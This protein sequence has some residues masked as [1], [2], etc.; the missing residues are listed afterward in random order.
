[1]LLS[2]IGRFSNYTLNFEHVPIL[3]FGSNSM[4]QS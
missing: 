2:K 4:S 1:M 3:D